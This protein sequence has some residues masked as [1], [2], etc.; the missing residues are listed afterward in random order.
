MFHQPKA[1]LQQNNKKSRERERE[2]IIIIFSREN[3]RDNKKFIE[4]WMRRKR[5]KRYGNKYKIIIVM[6]CNRISL[7]SYILSF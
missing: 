4:N 3:V 5:V 7:Y 6:Q 2:G 1:E